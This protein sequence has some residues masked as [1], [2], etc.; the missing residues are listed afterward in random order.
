MVSMFLRVNAG[1]TPEIV[2]A[3][4]SH[5]DWR[6][7]STFYFNEE[8]FDPYV[9]TPLQIELWNTLTQ[10]KSLSIFQDVTDIDRLCIIMS[11][12]YL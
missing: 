5:L 9:P 7:L 4:N 11:Y 1:A 8:V 2:L 12:V 10:R 6:N 3:D